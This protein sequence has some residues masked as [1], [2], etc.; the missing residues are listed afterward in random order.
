L[1]GRIGNGALVVW[2]VETAKSVHQF[3]PASPPAGNRLV[4]LRGG[5]VDTPGMAF[6]PDGKF[7]VASVTDYEKEMPVHSVKFWNLETGKESRKIKGPADAPVSAV[8]VAP[9]GKILAYGG[10]GVVHMCDAE[11]GKELHQLKAP[12][13]GF[14]GLLFSSDGKTLVSR[15]TNQRI[16]LWDTSTAKEIRHLGN[17]ATS[18]QMDVVNAFVVGAIPLGLEARDVAMSPDGRRIASASGNT[19]RLWD[20]STGKEL[21]LP[22]GHHRAPT[23]LAVSMDGKTAVSW[24]GDGIIRRWEAASGKSLGQFPAPTGT[25]LAVFSAGGELVALANSDGTVRV[26]DTTSGKQIHR[27]TGTQAGNA[28]RFNSGAGLTFSPD[29]KVLAVRGS[30]DSLIRLYDLNSGAEVRKIGL[31]NKNPAGPARAIVLAG[32]GRSAGPGLA[33][34]P[35]GRLLVSPAPTGN[36]LIV[37]DVATGKE[38]RRIAPAQPVSSF[39]FSPD[40]RVLAT[41]NAD[42]TVTLWEVASG[43]ERAHL[44]RSAAPQRND[45]RTA[46]LLRVGARVGNL[47]Q[48]FGPVGLSYSPDGRAL[49]VRGADRSVHLWDVAAGKEIGQLQ[50]HS[51]QVETVSFAPDGKSLVTAATDTTLL[52]WDAL[53]PLR[54]LAS[55]RQV[56]LSPEQLTTLW[57]DLAAEHGGK[58]LRGVLELA[59][60]PGQAVPFMRERMKP[61]E[62]IDPEKIRGWLADLDSAKF[63]VR[64]EASA[65]LLKCGDQALPALRKLLASS[66]TLEVR[67]RA[68]ALLDRLTTGALTT[69]Q[70][71]VVRAVEALERM[72]TPEARGL[73]RTLADGAPGALPTREAEAALSRLGKV[74]P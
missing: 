31:L 36:E 4:V 25:T 50:G 34:S 73:L 5:I 71:R 52:V 69:E 24:G 39:A 61:E 26:H 49:A 29:G 16:R 68:E 14:R 47:P 21:P 60:V 22:G 72:G 56:A 40:G 9:G 1:A 30:A 67:Q 51:G 63:T 46:Q 15:G 66:P 7:L 62:Q 65:S 59:N 53:D 57:G 44:G 45:A 13:G 8:A 43:K 2:D 54:A 19:V 20:L 41:D 55:P 33:F 6:T 17:P 11:T 28:R 42:R 27:F 70:L 18:E 35:D 74:T 64:Q 48:Q 23:A 58:A 12:D 37:L 3:L 38:L 10:R 32:P